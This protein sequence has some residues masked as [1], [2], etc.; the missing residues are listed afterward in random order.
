M[1]HV[2]DDARGQMREGHTSAQWELIAREK[3][4]RTLLVTGE[5]TADD[6]TDLNIPVEYRC[7]IHGAAT[8]YFSGAEPFMEYVERRKSERPSRKG[9]KN[10][11]FR[12]T[13]KGRAQLPDLLRDL[14]T[15]LQP[16]VGSS[17]GATGGT[18]VAIARSDQDQE[19]VG[20]T[21]AAE[22]LTG[23]RD[24][25]SGRSG[26]QSGVGN[27]PVTT[28]S[29]EAPPPNLAADSGSPDSLVQLDD[30]PR[31]VP[32]MYDPMEDAA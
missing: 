31:R 11:V 9:G 6:L 5:F 3:V 2:L 29:E 15:Q 23:P 27:S 13:A 25:R 19:I 17:N 22:A 21:A 1:T 8:G 10:D 4:M 26:D 30:A 24:R 14:H 7:H 16:L 18:G 20:S 32:S 12:I 28:K